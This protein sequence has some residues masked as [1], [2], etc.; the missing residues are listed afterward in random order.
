[1]I[2]GNGTNQQ[3]IW[4]NKDTRP[5]WGW[6]HHWEHLKKDKHWISSQSLKR[7]Y[8][9][10]TRRHNQNMLPH[11]LMETYCHASNCIST[12]NLNTNIIEHKY[13]NSHGYTDQTAITW[14]TYANTDKLLQ[15]NP[16]TTP[17]NKNRNLPQT[18]HTNLEK[19]K[20]HTHLQ[21]PH[22]VTN[23]PNVNIAGSASQTQ[24][25]GTP[26][27]KNHNYGTPKLTS[28]TE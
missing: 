16:Y 15:T 11:E 12:H 19:W 28:P 20:S 9:R 10:G 21:T 1:M 8:T 22:T 2:H 23:I 14:K 27:P 5:H 24:Y 4:Y 18:D 6:T 13:A 25:H 26:H 3:W 17:Y 7:N